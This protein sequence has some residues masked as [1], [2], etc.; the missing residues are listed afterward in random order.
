MLL[1][2]MQSDHPSIAGLIFAIIGFGAVA[3]GR[4]P[5]GLAN[6]LF[7]IGRW[8]RVR[9]TEQ[10]RESLPDLSSAPG[11]RRADRSA[12]PDDPDDSDD[13]ADFEPDDDFDP[14]PTSTEVPANV[15]P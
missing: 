11:R 13:S 12:D 5:N 2:V 9:A 10:L 3:L 1:P 14:A 6:H 4:D 8:V 15:A 7:R